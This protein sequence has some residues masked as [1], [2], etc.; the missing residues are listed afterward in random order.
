LGAQGDS[1]VIAWSTATIGGI[2]ITQSIPPSTIDQKDLERQCKDRTKEIVT[3]KKAITFG[4]STT[5]ASVCS[6]IRHDT[7]NVC[8]IS[9]F[10]PKFGCCF[11]SLVKLG[12]KGIVKEISMSLESDEQVAIVQSANQVKEVV[13][14]INENYRD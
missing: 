9:H 8:P 7:H 11:S 3:A 4:I 12:R 1:Q 2:P 10:Q 13:D 6:S 5:V 14:H